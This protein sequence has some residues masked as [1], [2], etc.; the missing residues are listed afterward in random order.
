MKT[1]T[2]IRCGKQFEA[3]VKTAVCPDCH[4]AVCVVCGKEFELK[5]PYI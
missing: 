4:T 5:H 1:Y 2:C 3:K